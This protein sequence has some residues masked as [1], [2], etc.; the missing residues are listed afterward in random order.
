MNTKVTKKYLVLFVSSLLL[1]VIFIY[2]EKNNYS[3]KLN[4]SNDLSEDSIHIIENLN[5]DD[6]IKFEVYTNKDSV[7]AK[8]IIKF[9]MPFKQLNQQIN[10]EFIDPTTHPSKVKAHAVTM[11]GEIVLSHVD[12]TKLNKINITELSESAVIN[13][14]QRLHNDKDEWM[15]FAEGYGMKTIDDEISTGLSKLLIHLK[16]IGI[17][18]A[19]MPLNISVILPDNVK[20]IVMPAP[21][22]ILDEGIVAWLKN[23]A[24]QGI[25]I[26]WLDDV[27]SANQVNLEL[28]FDVISGE[29]KLLNDKD[30]S[31]IITDFPQHVILE[32]FNQP[33]YLAEAKEIDATDSEVLV[34]TPSKEPLAISKQLVN[35]RLVITGDADFISNQYIDVAANKGLTIRILDWLFYHDE[36]INIP[37]TISHHTQLFLTKT[38]LVVMSIVFLIVLPLLLLFG[39]FKQWRSWYG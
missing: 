12:E 32:H 22:E 14:I 4:K 27:A 16:K 33:I 39:A 5:T 7:V 34:Q 11:Q 35:S 36:R 23:Q 24:V 13:A 38:Q 18:V 20:V 10:I 26:W 15:I 30:Y 21:T 29:K 6:A 25:S 37:V 31:A 8:K 2:L 17:H 28:A 9:F 3:F 1:L 19:R